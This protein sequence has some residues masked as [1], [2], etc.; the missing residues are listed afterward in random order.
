MRHIKNIF[1]PEALIL[2]AVLVLLSG[3]VREDASPGNGPAGKAPVQIAALADIGDKID[4]ITLGSVRII[5]ISGDNKVAFNE[6]RTALAG[7][8][9]FEENELVDALKSGNYIVDIV[10]GT[11]DF[12]AIINEYPS[13]TYPLGTLKTRAELQAISFTSAEISSLT[14]GS[15]VCV[16]EV[17][18][19][20]VYDVA[21]EGTPAQVSVADGTP[22]ST[23][24]MKIRRVAA[25]LTVKARKQT[26]GAAT[27]DTFTIKGAT[28]S[29]VPKNSYLLPKNYTGEL[30]Q[31]ISITLAG[32]VA[33]TVNSTDFTNVFT[34]YIMPEY[35]LATPADATKATQ[36]RL[37]ADYTLADDPIADEVEYTMPLL[38]QSAASYNISRNNHYV[39]NVTI[40]E[41][42]VF[43]YTPSIVYDVAKW[44]TVTDDPA[45]VTI[46]DVYTASWDWADDTELTPDEITA[47]VRYNTFVEMQFT[48]SHPENAEWMANLSN[49]Q[50]FYFDEVNGVRSGLAKAG[51]NNRIIIRPRDNA[52]R[53]A[54]TEIWITMNNGTFDVELDHNEDEATGPGHRYMIR[55]VPNM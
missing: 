52:A 16:G 51:A 7:N 26:T 50:D 3:C 48:L 15:M 44:D 35:L 13:H 39:V 55:L 32:S 22:T 12:Y 49:N 41:R 43:E 28:I 4:E 6:Y 40:S 46:D 9:K 25:K 20:Q 24:E 31:N 54:T 1:K 36:L 47:Y 10:P 23:L 38:G 8:L 14:E 37:T 18:N 30:N 19:V 33:F 34:G 27:D 53:D 21:S 11:Y 42:G 5:A 2:A 29:N 17:A 45:N